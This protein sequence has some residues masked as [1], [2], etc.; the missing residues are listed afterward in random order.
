MQKKAQGHMAS[1]V[2]SVSIANNHSQT[3]P[4]NAGGNT[5]QLILQ[6]RYPDTQQNQRLTSL[7]NTG[8]KSLKR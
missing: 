8:V 4:E 2:H 7:M 3:L 5:S 1:P 6:G